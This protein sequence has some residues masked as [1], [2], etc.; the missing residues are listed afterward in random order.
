MST[1]TMIVV[2]IDRTLATCRDGASAPRAASARDGGGL[3][4]D[5]LG[6]LG[7]AEQVALREVAAELAQQLQLPGGLDP[8]G[9]DV[10]PER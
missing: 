7:S 1:T 4:H 3:E 5:E 2:A 10:E 8:L 6:R 9:D